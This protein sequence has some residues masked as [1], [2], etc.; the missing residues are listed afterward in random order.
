MESKKEADKNTSGSAAK[1]QNDAI[2]VDEFDAFCSGQMD[3]MAGID[4]PLP[5]ESRQGTAVPTY[6]NTYRL[7]PCK[8]FRPVQVQTVIETAFF[9]LLEEKVYDHHAAKQWT[10]ALCDAIKEK[11][12]LLDFPRFKIVC[13]VSIGQRDRQD[14]HI[15]SRCLWNKTFD[16]FASGAYSNRSL[17]AV[18]VVYAVY[19]E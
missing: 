18:G 5:A 9:E 8:K 11:V 19:F 16:G 12:K 13:F 4:T 10:V 1:G 6:E 14:V 3:I 17:Y 7:Q 2:T 15:G